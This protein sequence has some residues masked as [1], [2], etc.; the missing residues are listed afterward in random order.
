MLNNDEASFTQNQRIVISSYDPITVNAQAVA[1][2]FG[3]DVGL[4]ILSR[5]NFIE[6]MRLTRTLLTSR[7]PELHES[8]YRAILRLAT[9]L[10]ASYYIQNTNEKYKQLEQKLFGSLRGIRTA[11]SDHCNCSN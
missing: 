8:A 3:E 9:I 6:A 1:A 5:N 7:K 10:E 4:E 11:H 2:L